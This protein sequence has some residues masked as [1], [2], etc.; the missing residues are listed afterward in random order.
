MKF[1]LCVSLLIILT[2]QIDIFFNPSFIQTFE[3]SKINI[4]DTNE[5]IYDVHSYIVTEED[6]PVEEIKSY[7]SN[8]VFASDAIH[9]IE[10]KKNVKNITY[11]E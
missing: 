8:I 10:N 1:I 11:Y 7:R 2:T 9:V 6:K 3:K 4:L 5:I